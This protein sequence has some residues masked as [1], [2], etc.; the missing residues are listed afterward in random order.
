M[1]F[2]TNRIPFT[3]SL[4]PHTPPPDADAFSPLRRLRHLLLSS[5]L[6]THLPRG[7]P[8][9]LPASTRIAIGNNPYQCACGIQW[10]L[11]MLDAKR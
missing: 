11:T 2:D 1:L 3:V 8:E 4:F 9:S 5:N 7:V 10:L 6:L